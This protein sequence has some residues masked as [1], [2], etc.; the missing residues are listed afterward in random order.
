M[1]IFWVALVGALG[2]AVAGWRPGYGFHDIPL[3][4]GIFIAPFI[5]MIYGDIPTAMI[6]AA[7]IDMMYIGMIAPGAEMPADHYLAAIIGTALGVGA[8][9]DPAAAVA[10]AVPFGVFGVFLNTFRRLI[11]GWFARSADKCAENGDAK[12]IARNAIIKPLILNLL[13]KFPVCFIIIYFGVDATQAIFSAM[14]T[15]LMHGLQVGG[16]MLPAIGFA[17]LLKIMGRKEIIAFFFIGFAMVEYF[18][19]STIGVLCFALPVAVIY[20]MLSNENQQEVLNKAKLA[21]ASGND[22]DDDE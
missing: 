21:M 13:T 6:I 7:S 10:L 19:L 22:D 12:G 3:M 17:L 14:P 9:L 15:W 8:G 4:W 1:T 18:G 20:V 2:Y 5:G 11:N 16:G